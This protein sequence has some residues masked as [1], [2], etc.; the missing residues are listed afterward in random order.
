MNLDFS[1]E[2]IMLRTM[3]R[4][5][6]TD[7]FP[8]KVVGELEESETGHS[9]DIWKEMVELGWM[10]LALPEEYGGEGMTFLDLAVVLEEMGRA[11][12]PGPYFS[13]V[14]LGALPILALGS[15]EQKK[16]YLPEIASGRYI[17]TLA[18][19]E[20]SA[21]YDAAGIQMK[22]TPDG[23]GYV[24]NGTKLFVPD[25]HLADYM[26]CAAR[27]GEGA[28]PEDG[29]TLFIVDAKSVG[30]TCSLLNTIAKDKQCEAVFDNVKVPA[31]NIIGEPGNGWNSV[32]KIIEMAA[33]ATCCDIVGSLQQVFEMTLDYAKERA[34]FGQPIGS[35]QAVQHH[36]ANMAIDVNGAMLS[37]YQAAWAVSEGLPCSWEVAVAKAWASQACPRVIALAH[38][39]HGA[40]GITMDHDLHYYTRRTKAAE[41]AFGDADFYQRMV[42]EELERGI[43]DND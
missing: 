17:F 36:C 35:F 32:K 4:D 8:K 30:I 11:C 28:S 7:K 15:E 40:I 43:A 31:E 27:T 19:M 34:A 41:S 1:E 24:L 20:E 38:Q 6:L 21:R 25:A 13:T 3:A 29:V 16:K 37:A 23:D 33:A 42:A 18:L 10:G 2:Q 14:V 12:V 9:P 22:S 5:F 26:L 39:I